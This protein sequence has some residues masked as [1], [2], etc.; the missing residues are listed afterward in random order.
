MPAV[1]EPR[2]PKVKAR[3]D[4]LTK[5]QV[6]YRGHGSA[7]CAELGAGAGCF[8]AAVDNAY[9]MDDVIANMHLLERRSEDVVYDIV[10]DLP[11][12]PFPQLPLLDR[13]QNRG[14]V[15]TKPRSHVANRC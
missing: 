12:D 3:R 6:L 1:L 9:E 5:G 2:T 4:A 14:E 7:A 10:P 11:R 13:I 15:R 8:T